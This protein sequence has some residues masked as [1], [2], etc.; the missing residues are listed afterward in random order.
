MLKLLVKKLIPT[1]KLPMRMTKGSAGYDLYAAQEAIVKPAK[2]TEDG[3]VEIG[4]ALI[5]TGLAIAIPQGFVGRIASRSGLSVNYNIEVGA[6][7]IDSDYR[8]ELLVELK[9]LSS[10][11]F[12]VAVGDRI[13]QLVLIELI[14]FELDEV[15]QLDYTERGPY[16]FG[17]TG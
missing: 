15:E 5:R 2:L 6:G 9:N 1:A 3:N 4:R 7:W 12:Y 8:G 13:A 14:D 16:G 11:P 10:K 17:S